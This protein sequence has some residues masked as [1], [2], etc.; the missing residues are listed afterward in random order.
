[1]ALAENKV[2]WGQYQTVVE[3]LDNDPRAS[4]KNPV[5]ERVT[6][7]GIGEHI[8]AGATVRAPA[9]ARE[10]MQPAPYLGTHTD[11]VL[12]ELLGLDSGAI[13]RLHDAGIVAGP[14]QDPTAV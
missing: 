10:A 1:M 2:C 9:L 6:T 5:F 8:S 14:E 4:L 13:G 7:P 12:S 3:L 11:E